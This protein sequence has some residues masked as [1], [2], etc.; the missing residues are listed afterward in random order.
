MKLKKLCE[1]VKNIEIFGSKEIEITGICADSR[2]ASPGSLF[3]ARKGARFDGSQYIPQALEAGSSAV[4][5]DL[6]NPAYRSLSQLICCDVDSAAAQL[7]AAFYDHPSKELQLIGVTGT[8]GKT[9]CSYLIRH[10]LQKTGS[11]CGLIGTIEYLVGDLRRKASL[12]T[13][14]AVDLQKMLREMVLEGCQAAVMEVSSHGLS[15]KRVASL[16]F[17][18]ALFTNLAIDHLDFHGSMQRYAE[19]KRLLFFPPTPSLPPK[20][21]IINVDDPFGKELYRDFSGVKIGYGFDPAADLRI[22]SYAPYKKGTKIE[23]CWQR[24]NKLLYT[25]YLGVHNVYNCVAAAAVGL[26]QIKCSW[27]AI[28]EALNSAPSIPGRL[29]PVAINQH[30][31]QS[32]K[33]Q[34]LIYIDFAHTP[35][36]LK[37][38]LATLREYHPQRQLSIVFGCG[39]G[40]DTQ[41]RSMMAQLAEQ[42]ADSIIVTNDNPRDEDPSAIFADIISGF[43]PQANYQLHPDRKEAIERAIRQS[44]S[45]GV[46]LIAGKGHEKEQIIGGRLYPFDDVSIARDALLSLSS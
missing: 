39:G 8:D 7:A 23:L 21:A 11:Y 4:L 26:S 38:V 18:A 36:A 16:Q 14:E 29:E 1:Q 40:R 43:S 10:L 42:F 20:A 37:C 13:P 5:T 3:I 17:E 41:K 2:K 31:E 45:N 33:E 28:E 25:P 44:P 9:T 35:Q 15:L 27:N 12:T 19:A 6:Y 22:C 32:V 30:K 34:P 24:Q 46:V